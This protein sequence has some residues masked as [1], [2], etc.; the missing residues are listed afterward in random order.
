MNLWG[1]YILKVVDLGLG[2]QNFRILVIRNIY[3]HHII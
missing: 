3:N 1:F 2:F